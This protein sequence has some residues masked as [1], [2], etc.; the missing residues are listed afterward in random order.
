VVAFQVKAL[1]EQAATATGEIA[2]RS[3]SIQDEDG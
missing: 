2:R 1:P 3:L